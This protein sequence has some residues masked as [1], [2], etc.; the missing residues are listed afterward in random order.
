MPFGAGEAVRID[1]LVWDNENE[2][3]FYL[4]CIQLFDCDVLIKSV[5]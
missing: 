2:L 5:H 3:H 4:S 1:G